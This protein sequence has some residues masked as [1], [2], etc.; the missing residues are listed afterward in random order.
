MSIPLNVEQVYTRIR[1]A[2]HRGGRSPESVRLIAV[3]KT[4]GVPE[5]RELLACGPCELGEN[6]VQVALPKIE[7]IGQAGIHWHLIGH[8]QSN[9]IKKAVSVFEWIHSIDSVDC[10]QEISKR[11]LEIGKVIRGLIEVNVSR[12]LSKQGVAP[13]A[14]SALLTEC[15]QL[16]GL[17]LEGLMTMA[18]VVADPELVRPVFRR[19]KALA[20]EQGLTELSMGMS[21]DFEIAIEEGAT[22]VRVGR[23]LWGG[24]IMEKMRREESDC[25]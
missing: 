3:T 6:R 24:S 21:D 2:A 13:E 9:K 4:I 18:P 10:A 11:A 15:R 19:L 1:Q 14:L 16:P 17:S 20:N 5:I 12:E 8:L 7:A 23:V 22:M 25:L